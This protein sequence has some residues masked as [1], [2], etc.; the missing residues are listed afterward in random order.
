MILDRPL[1][2]FKYLKQACQNLNL[3]YEI[4]DEHGNL[5]CVNQ[6]YFA[7]HSTP[8]NDISVGRICADK[9]FTYF[10][11]A[12]QVLMPKTVGFL[13]PKVRS[14][15]QL[16]RQDKT[17]TEIVDKIETNFSYPL[18]VKM[19]Q[20]RQGQ[21]VFLCDSRQEVIL[22]LEKIYDK[23]S[24]F[25]DYVA[26]AQTYIKSVK[27]YKVIVF[28]GEIILA[29]EKDLTKA[30]F[31][32]NLSPLHWKGSRALY[33]NDISLIVRLK[34]AIKPIFQSI[35]LEFGSIDI[36]VNQDGDLYIIELNANP[37]FSI[38]LRDNN[39]ELVVKMY[40]VLLSGLK[41]RH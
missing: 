2:H 5:L 21:N 41:N 1:P 33:V 38:F 39:P 16:Y 23:Q 37:G 28:R 7:N 4:K 17:I 32:G 8:F 36:I 6:M 34:Q 31:T 40:E 18:I 27:E 10:I 29:Y 9:E 15:Y 22:A 26:L 13:N 12:N 24:R 25:Y 30:V 11:L 19:N 14:N 3:D 20:G 35:N